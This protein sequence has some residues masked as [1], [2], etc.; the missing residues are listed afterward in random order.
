[1][2][3]HPLL[4]T[5]NLTISFG[6]LRAVD[7]VDF[8]IE[9]GEIVGLIGPNG[10]GKT[11]FF[12]IISG[13]YKPNKGEVWFE[14][15]SIL[16]KGPHEITRQGMARTFQHSRLFW[17][18][19][20]L[21]NVII[22][23]HTKQKATLF[24]VLFREKKTREELDACAVKAQQ[25]LN[26]FSPDLSDNCYKV[27]ADLPQ[28]DRRRVEICRA[29]ASDPKLL[30]FDEPS[31]GMSPEE[32][33]KLMEDIRKVKKKDE[34]ISLI[35]IEHDMMVIEKIAQRVI[36][37]NYGKKIADG[38]FLEISEDKRVLEAYLGEELEDAG[39]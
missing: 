13:I 18:L 4:E 6:G 37:F 24:D 17:Q 1:M 29:L 3:D 32:T 7:G 31:A 36:V 38:T 14:K 27:V 19:S 35:I 10:S 39:A 11:T 25:L 12:N 33:E 34:S 26:Y 28:G 8:H 20:I 9:P 22:G 21:D 15:K 30:L 23:M 2:N 5:R 16:G